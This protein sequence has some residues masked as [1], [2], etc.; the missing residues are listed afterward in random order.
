VERH[1]EE[2][3]RLDARHLNYEIVAHPEIAI[4]DSDVNGT[5]RNSPEMVRSVVGAAQ[6]A[7]VPYKIGAAAFGAGS[8]AAPFSRA[9]LKALALMAFKIPQQQLAFY[10]QD[11]DTPDVLTIEPLLNVLK[12]SLEWVRAGGE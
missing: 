11:R 3:K 12:L 2:L 4:M 9:G 8:D 10:H 1:L 5:V 7:G 6:R